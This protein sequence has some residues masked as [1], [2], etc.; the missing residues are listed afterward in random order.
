MLRKP[1]RAMNAKVKL[2]FNPE[3]VARYR[4]VDFENR[5]RPAHAARISAM[6]K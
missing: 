1:S 5:A 6:I 3:V 4:L 2:D